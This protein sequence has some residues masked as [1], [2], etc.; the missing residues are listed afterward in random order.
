MDVMVLL[1]LIKT[2]ELLQLAKFFTITKTM[3]IFQI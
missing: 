2:K 3:N 1:L